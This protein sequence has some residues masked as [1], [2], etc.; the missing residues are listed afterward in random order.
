MGTIEEEQRIKEI[1]ERF[2]KLH[3]QRKWYRFMRY[4]TRLCLS[5]TEISR[6]MGF[7]I[8]TVLYWKDL[9]K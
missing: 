9:I 2:C 3:G 7:T 4:S 6:I 5:P 8:K 1:Q